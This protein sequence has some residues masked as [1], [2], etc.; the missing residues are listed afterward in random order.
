MPET[1]QWEAPRTRFVDEVEF[2]SGDSVQISTGVKLKVDLK[3]KL[4]FVW[5]NCI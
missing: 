3:S 2:R 5:S 1:D 4:Y